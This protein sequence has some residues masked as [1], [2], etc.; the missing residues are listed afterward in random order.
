M[1]EAESFCTATSRRHISSDTLSPTD[2]SEERPAI[3]KV[4]APAYSETYGHVD[5]SQNGLDTE[6][7]VA[8]MTPS[9]LM[10]SVVNLTQAMDVS[11]SRLTKSRAGFRICWCPRYVA[12]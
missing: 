12:S 9:N 3:E 4:P 2:K 7:R 1:L 8:R 10:L 5:F 6:A 11:T